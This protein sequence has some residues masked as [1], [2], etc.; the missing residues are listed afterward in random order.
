MFGA[1]PIQ[2]EE[3]DQFLEDN[4]VHERWRRLF[5]ETPALL[6]GIRT[7]INTIS[8]DNS[9]PERQNVLR[10]FSYLPPEQVKVVI[11]GHEPIANNALATGL[12]FSFPLGEIIDSDVGNPGRSTMWEE[13]KSVPKVHDA[14]CKAG[15]LEQGGM[16]DCC[17]EVWA[18]RG[19]LLL[20][21][22][23]T[24]FPDFIA[25]FVPQILLQVDLLSQASPVFVAC[26]G[27]N[28]DV[29]GT[30]FSLLLASAGISHQVIRYEESQETREGPQGAKWVIYIGHNP[31]FPRENNFYLEQAAQQFKEINEVY[32]GLFDLE[33]LAVAAAHGPDDQGN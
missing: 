7:I 19:V 18:T 22:A 31:T 8:P 1:E 10:A 16:Y 9:V 15:I 24:R 23:L 29:V 3:V 21:A 14:L 13:G 20:N 26:W 2:I 30:G 11:V 28:A 33:N 25:E 4:N 12:A 17:H 27:T 5:R 32:P 6:D